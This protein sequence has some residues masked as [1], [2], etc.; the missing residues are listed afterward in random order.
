M[1]TCRQL[2]PITSK[3]RCRHCQFVLDELGIAENTRFAWNGPAEIFSS[4]HCG[5]D[6]DGLAQQNLQYFLKS[7]PM[8]LKNI[9]V[10]VSGQNWVGNDG[11]KELNCAM[12]HLISSNK[13]TLESID[14]AVLETVI[15]RN[16]RISKFQI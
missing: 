16:Y 5:K 8:S 13:D 10:S 4:S 14:F 15:S 1:K 7:F 3:Y 11:C 2:F 12:I 6:E 9:H